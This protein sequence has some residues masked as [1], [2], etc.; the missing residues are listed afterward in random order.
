MTALEKTLKKILSGKHDR[1]ITFD[2]IFK[3]LT[4][5]GWKLDRVKGSHHIFRADSGRMLNIPKHGNTVKPTC[6][7]E[8]RERLKTQD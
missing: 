8:V 1:N 7:R 2:E 5:S 6:V 3:A 4:N